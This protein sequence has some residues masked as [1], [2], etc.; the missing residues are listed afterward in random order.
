MK[1]R[2]PIEVSARH[3]HLSK[4]DLEKLFGKGYKIKVLRKLYQPGEFAAT[5]TI[6]LQVNSNRFPKLRVTGPLRKETQIELSQTD[7]IFLGMNVP[8]RKSGD[9]KG[10]PGAFLIGPKGKVKIKRGIIN[11]WRHIHCNLQEAK[12]LGIKNGDLVSVK[13]KGT[14]S[15]T[16][17]NVMVRVGE[18]YKLSMHLDADEGNAARITQKGE[19]IL[20][21]QKEK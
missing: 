4:K 17:H 21:N 11:A 5:E 16:F 9:F 2:I 10:T 3:I 19:G 15:V 8:I 18:N 1:T 7:A 6:E 20:L 14:G 13:T 12:K